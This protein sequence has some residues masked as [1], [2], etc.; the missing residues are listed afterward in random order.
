M[1]CALLH[2]WHCYQPHACCLAVGT[3]WV[4]SAASPLQAYLASESEDEGQEGPPAADVD[5]YRRL[6][7]EA[8]NAEPPVHRKGGKDW[9]AAANGANGSQVR[10]QSDAAPDGGLL[11][12]S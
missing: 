8:A 3:H 6:L 1:L 9:V 11:H 10:A 7:L 12:I 5:Q 4:K 2:S